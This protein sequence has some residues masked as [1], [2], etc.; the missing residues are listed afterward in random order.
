[1]DTDMDYESYFRRLNDVVVYATDPGTREVSLLHRQAEG[2]WHCALCDSVRCRH[3]EI[4]AL[5][6]LERDAGGDAGDHPGY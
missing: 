3:S 4:A 2:A 5:A 6:D 1:M